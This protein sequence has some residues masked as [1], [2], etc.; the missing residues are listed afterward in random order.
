MHIKS[1]A[2]L[3]IN[4]TLHHCSHLVMTTGLHTHIQS[5]A[6]TSLSVISKLWLSGRGLAV[7][8]VVVLRRKKLPPVSTLAVTACTRT[9]TAITRLFVSASH[10]L[11]CGRPLVVPGRGL[12]RALFS[13]RDLPCAVET[14]EVSR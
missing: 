5:Q 11:G 14:L 1:C 3:P 8:V 12:G 2:R 9:S 4:H 6:C 7:E 13:S 10:F